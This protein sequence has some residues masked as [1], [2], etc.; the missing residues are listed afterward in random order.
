[1]QYFQQSVNFQKFE[2]HLHRF[3]RPYAIFFRCLK[4]IFKA[5]FNNRPVLT[6]PRKQLFPHLN[7]LCIGIL[8]SRLILFKMDKIGKNVPDGTGLYW[9]VLY[10]TEPYCTV[11]YR[12]GQYW[13]VLDCTG[14]YWTV[15]DDRPYCTVLDRTEP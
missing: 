3:K 2:M 13:T 5:F 7:T 15:L 10:C 6:K 14:P 4:L 8:I 9:T 1:M 11:L 12:T